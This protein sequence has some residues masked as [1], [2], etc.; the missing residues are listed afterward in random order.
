[1]QLFNKKICTFENI[2][3]IFIF[4]NL[5]FTIN[6]KDFI[7]D[8]ICQFPRFFSLYKENN[9]LCCKEGIYTYNLNFTEQLFFHK[10]ETEISKN[11]GEFITMAQFPNNGNV[12]IITEDK[13][14]LL[15]SEGEFLFDDDLSFQKTCSYYAL[16]PFIYDNNDNFVIG[17]LNDLKQINLLFYKIDYSLK[18]NE[19]VK[20]YIPSVINGNGAVGVNYL[21]GF[22]CQIMNSNNI[23]TLVCFCSHS[24]PI[25]IAAFRISINS[26][27]ELID[28]SFTYLPLTSQAKFIKS[29]TSQDKSKCLI[30]FSDDIGSGYYT[31]YDISTSTFA[32]KVK[33]MTIRG[34]YAS[35]LLVQ[36]FPRTQEYILSSNSDNAFTITK[37]DKN[38]NR[39]QNENMNSGSTSDFSLGTDCSGLNFYNVALIP[40]YENY[41]FITDGNC[42]GNITARGY[43]F[44]DVFKPDEIYPFP[45]FLQNTINTNPSTTPLIDAVSSI[46]TTLP[47]T[48]I[49]TSSSTINHL[50]TTSSSIINNY[51]TSSST[52]NH[53]STTSSSIINNFHTSSSFIHYSSTISIS[54]NE[55]ESNNDVAC[56]IEFFYKNIKTNQCENICSDYEFLNNICYINDINENNI[57]NITEHVRKLISQIEVNKNTNIVINGN[58]VVYQL[59]SSEAMDDNLDKNISII[60]FG[61]CETKLKNKFDID[62]ILVLKIDVFLSTSTNI[63]L[64]YEVYN[65]LTLDKIDLSICKDMTIN[66]YLPY[67]ISD[68]ELDLYINLN[69]SGYDLYNPNDSFYLDICTPYTTYN[70][71]DILLSDR[72]TDFY[73]N[74]SFC[75]EGCTYKNYDYT[76][77]KVQC[78]CQTKTELNNNI[79]D[80]KFYSNSFSSAFFTLENFSN[81]KVIKCLKLV[82]SLLGQTMNIGSYIFIVFTLIYVI[83]IILF[84]KDGKKKFLEIINTF[85]RSQNIKMP[86]KKKKKN[87]INKN[88]KKGNNKII[89][90]KNIIIN[91]HYRNINDKSSGLLEPEDS[92]K[93][94]YSKLFLRKKTE[95][96]HKLS[97]KKK[98]KPTELLIHKG[99]KRNN[100][101]EDTENKGA[102]FVQNYQDLHYNDYE[103]N[104]LTYEKAIIYDNRTYL[105]YYCSL[106]KEKHLIIF[107][108]ISSNDYNLF[109]I[110][111]SL[112][113]FSVSLN[114]AVNTLFFT[115]TIIHKI[116]E[117][118][119]TSQLIYS[120]MNILYST[121][122]SSTISIS[123]KLLALSNKSILKLKT[124]NNK[125]KNKNKK[126]K[127]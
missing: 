118:P 52:I 60:D 33:Y 125:M 96:I 1:M 76:Y 62:F 58:N 84:C 29:V 78:E 15:S 103:L 53:L 87:D 3:F 9:I 26:D 19:L 17:S 116:Y 41:I 117:K 63:V 69:E 25:E 115:D 71:T 5:I 43:L 23:N 36:Y 50:T 94:S 70:K 61:E 37:L 64:K 14:Y 7:I 34:N 20:N 106:L 121:I 68:E 101:K 114:F 73:K 99:K 127:N 105:Q 59:I 98:K 31:I 93:K 126:K 102:Q 90:N 47:F 39:I 88:I 79:N 86:I 42:K 123:L 45:I 32:D 97:G 46:I 16:V 113:I 28:D 22:S 40:E 72:R 89:I 108:F 104:S 4:T 124:D 122:I 74:K 80:V 30:I 49:Y 81:I 95:K 77:E 82:F 112:F 110:K 66:T 35:G 12:I 100:K 21:K 11:N 56:S 119:T 8:F 107:T 65:P 18:K 120:L 54:K 92:T 51:H 83:L 75:E 91:N 55:N 24:Y 67:P 2:T 13:F 109:I 6:C 48:S 57:M 38:M 10:F 44:P 85:K 27:F 111:L